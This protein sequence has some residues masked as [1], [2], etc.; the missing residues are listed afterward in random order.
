M[1]VRMEERMM[2]RWARRRWDLRKE[3]AGGAFFGFFVSVCGCM[4]VWGGGGLWRG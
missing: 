1:L 3:G 4:C 2:S